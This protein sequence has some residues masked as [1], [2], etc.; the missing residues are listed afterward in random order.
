MNSRGLDSGLTRVSEP[1]KGVVRIGTTRRKSCSRCSYRQ[2]VRSGAAGGTQVVSSALPTTILGLARRLDRETE[3]FQ[4][5]VL[6]FVRE[7]IEDRSVSQP[8]RRAR[9][10]T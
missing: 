9:L 4:N 10:R 2:V 1:F 5:H 7:V 6:D 3:V 8:R